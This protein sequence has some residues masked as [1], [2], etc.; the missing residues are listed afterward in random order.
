MHAYIKKLTAEE[1]AQAYGYKYV[2]EKYYSA[3]CKPSY[4]FFMKLEDAQE[5]ADRINN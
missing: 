5:Y 3:G 4:Y 2:V 1:S